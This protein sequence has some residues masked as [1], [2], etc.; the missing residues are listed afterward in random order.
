MWVKLSRIEGFSSPIS[1]VT[2]SG[3]LW[4]NATLSWVR[5]DS[6]GMK[7]H[8]SWLGEST[9]KLSFEGV[10][11]P[12]KICLAGPSTQRPPPWPLATASKRSDACWEKR[13]A[14]S[15]KRSV[16]PAVRCS[17]HDRRR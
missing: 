12:R 8:R 15:R 17:D 4:D 5:E 10:A 7:R 14:E 1:H 11:V 9:R 6:V 3:A 13:S 2:V 16:L